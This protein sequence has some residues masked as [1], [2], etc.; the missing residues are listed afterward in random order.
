MTMITLS[1]FVTQD[2]IAAIYG[3]LIKTRPVLV[4]YFMALLFI[5]R[6]QGTSKRVPR[7]CRAKNSTGTGSPHARAKPL[8]PLPY[9]SLKNV[10]DV[11]SQS[12]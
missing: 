6:V 10:S 5:V 1:Q 2:S 4:I 3:P 9:D 8:L 12:P 11:R 7:A